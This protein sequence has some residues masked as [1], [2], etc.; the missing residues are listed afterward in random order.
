MK[1][2]SFIYIGAFFIYIG[3]FLGLPPHPTSG[4]AG[5]HLPLKGEGL[6]LAAEFGRGQRIEH[7]RDG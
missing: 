3:A 5:R 2:F 1:N 6:A 7:C 4:E